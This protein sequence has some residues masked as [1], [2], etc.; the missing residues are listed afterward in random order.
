MAKKNPKPLTIRVTPDL[1]DTKA[2]K[3]LERKGHDIV[4]AE[5]DFDMILSAKAWRMFVEFAENSDLVDVAVKAARAVKFR[6]KTKE[7]EDDET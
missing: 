4:V 7:D 5:D 1:Y 6:R 2:V 3:E